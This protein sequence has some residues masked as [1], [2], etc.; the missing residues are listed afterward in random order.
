MP[1]AN[2]IALSRGSFRSRSGVRAR[3][4][5]GSGMSDE[6]PLVRHAI[7]GWGFPIS[8]MNRSSSSMGWSHA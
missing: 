3:I 5:F 8:A 6:D 2:A 4:D 7:S 1:P